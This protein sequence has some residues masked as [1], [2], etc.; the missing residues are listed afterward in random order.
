LGENWH[1]FHHAFPSDYR[2]GPKWYHLDVHKWIIWTFA[3]LGL[4]KD[5]KY[6]SDIRIIAHRKS[7]LSNSFKNISERW[8]D[9]QKRLHVEGKLAMSSVNKTTEDF[10]VYTS[11]AFKKYNKDLSDLSLQIKSLIDSE[12]LSKRL[13]N[14]FSSLLAM[15]EYNLKKFEK[16]IFSTRGLV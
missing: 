10:K 9:L 2:N 13:I 8:T 4:A 6:T 16:E 7:I 15:F 1:N 3:K 12:D 5:L 14:E 11:S